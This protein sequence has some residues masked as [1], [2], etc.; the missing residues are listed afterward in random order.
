MGV[1]DDIGAII[2]RLIGIIVLLVFLLPL[3]IRGWR[4]VFDDD[5]TGVPA[6]ITN[7][8]DFASVDDVENAVYNGVSKALDEHGVG[9]SNGSTQASPTPTPSGESNGGVVEYD[10][11]GKHNVDAYQWSV[12]I[13]QDEVLIIGGEEATVN[14]TDYK[15]VV[16]AFGPGTYE[17]FKVTKGFVMVVKADSA[18]AKFNEA[19][20]AQKA[21]VSWNLDTCSGL[22]GWKVD[23]P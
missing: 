17:H 3:G 19:I 6:H 4:G 11:T 10:S 7:T 13:R 2:G 1:R 21:Q 16:K 15:H 18:E 23:C 5:K 12:T 9:S 20:A 14:G 8:Q 22:S